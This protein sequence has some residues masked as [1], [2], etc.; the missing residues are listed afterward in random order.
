MMLRRVSEQDPY[1]DVGH[2]ARNL[3]PMYDDAGVGE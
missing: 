3:R 2:D 1:E